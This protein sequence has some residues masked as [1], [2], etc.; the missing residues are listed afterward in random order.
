[1]YPDFMILV[2]LAL[3]WAV[4]FILHSVLASLLCKS[5]FARHFPSWLARYRLLYNLLSVVLLIPVAFLMLRFE[6][7]PLWRWEGLLFWLS[8][9]LALA[10]VLAFV[11]SLRRYEMTDF[12]GLRGWNRGPGDPRDKGGLRI[13]YWHRYVR[14]P[15]YFFALVILWTRDMNAAQL[16]SYSMMS[17]Y[18]VVGSRLEE[19][20]L[21]VFHGD[22]YREFQQRVPALFP[23][24][25]RHLSAEEARRLERRAQC[26]QRDASVPST[27]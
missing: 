20:K 24:P 19:Q 12:S 9:G 27:G 11:A 1:M 26:E 13:S 4:Y 25:W 16:V 17:L 6:A 2:V 3:Y 14:H 23:L 22:A 8:N 7:E 10:A 21:C 5:W 15:W 18:F